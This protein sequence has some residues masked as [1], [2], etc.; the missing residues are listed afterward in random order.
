M[1]NKWEPF[2]ITPSSTFFPVFSKAIK[3]VEFGKDSLEISV[4]N[5]DKSSKLKKV[6]KE[7]FR[8]IFDWQ[9]KD[10]CGVEVFRKMGE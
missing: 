3:M 1:K 6:V 7:K 5:Q 2:I 9:D 10:I 8:F 4:V